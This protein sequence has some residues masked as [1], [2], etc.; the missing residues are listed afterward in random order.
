MEGCHLPMHERRE[1]NTPGRDFV[2]GALCSCMRVM[3][4]RIRRTSASSMRGE[5]RRCACDAG[6]CITT[7]RDQPH[8]IALA[9]GRSRDTPRSSSALRVSRGLCLMPPTRTS[10]AG[11][12]ARS[13]A[14][15]SAPCGDRFTGARRACAW[16]PYRPRWSVASWP[17]WYGPRAPARP[18]D[19][20][21][22]G[23][24]GVPHAS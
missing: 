9:S 6:T 8:C 3:D 21:R 20:P 17:G 5:R 7:A 24:R 12:C 16:P 19:C 2:Y 1:G 4:D 11:V 14:P 10:A 22:P 13:A 18:A 23:R 15:P